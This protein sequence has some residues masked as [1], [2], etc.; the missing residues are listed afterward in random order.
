MLKIKALLAKILQA[1]TGAGKP[2]TMYRPLSSNQTSNWTYTAPY[3]GV[4]YLN[5]VSSQR[6]YVSIDW[7]GARMP[8]VAITTTSPNALLPYTM[9]LKKGDKVQID[10]LNSNCYLSATTTSFV[11]WSFQ[12]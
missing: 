9:L 6:S 2:Q 4:L 1:L 7:N 12:G 11:A 3:N 10:G 5:F 8:H